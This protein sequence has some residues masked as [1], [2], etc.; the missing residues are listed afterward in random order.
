M[1]NSSSGEMLAEAI[2]YAKAGLRI[3]P[4]RPLSKEPAIKAWQD[5][6]TAETVMIERW[7]G[8]RPSANIGLACGPQPNGLN[9]LA[10]DLDP[11]HGGLETWGQLI[12]EHPTTFTGATIHTTPNGGNHV[13]TN[14]PSEYRNTRAKLGPGIDTRGAGGYV[15]LPPSRV[16]DLNG[17]V[18]TYERR[19]MTALTDAT[20]IE[21]WPW[22]LAR[23]SQNV[24][25]N[26]NGHVVSP[27]VI[28]GTSP[29]DLLRAGWD[30]HG[31]L[32]ADGWRHVKDQGGDRYYAR[33]GKTDRGHSAVVH[34]SGA[35]V[36]FTT[37]APAALERIGRPTSD[38]T[39]FSVSPAHYVTAMRFGGDASAAARWAKERFG[40]ASA[41]G[42]HLSGPA[43]ADVNGVISP[44]AAP[45]TLIVDPGFW[46]ESALLAHVHTAAW[47]V[48][49]APMA[50]L[51]AVLARYATL[52]PPG[53][54][55]P[56]Y[57]SATATF[58][59]MTVIAGRSGAGKT[60]MLRRAAELIPI[61]DTQLLMERG[62]G[63]GEGLIEAFYGNVKVQG[64]D[65]K[66][67]SE[68][69]Q[70]RNGVNFSIDE[71]A[72]F[73]ELG[74][75]A[76]TTHVSRLCSAWSGAPLS[77][78]NA[79]QETIRHLEHGQYRLTACMG[80]QT[81]LG[82]TLMNTDV[83]TQGFTGRLL[84]GWGEDPGKPEPG[85]R[86]DDPGELAVAVPPVIQI[87][88]R[89]ERVDVAY[90]E[91][92]F[93]EVQ[94]NDHRREGTD[95]P[96]VEHHHD[97]LRLKIA[98]ILAL[99]EN[100]RSVSER[101]W[102]L[103]TVLGDHSRAVRSHLQIVHS[104]E[105]RVARHSAAAV[106]AD[107]ELVIESVKER[108][109]IASMAANIRTKTPQEGI[110]RNKLSKVVSATKTRHRFEAALELA[111]S[112]GWVTS[113]GERVSRA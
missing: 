18:Q 20:L 108:Q 112:N 57:L 97:L 89:H 82:H 98:G 28:N 29:F 33:P 105:S 4:L 61:S 60:S 24:I 76:G 102:G 113:D 6:A 40:N 27:A 12:A 100:E 17:E 109:G 48:G 64:D 36:V 39:G 59:L 83:T 111:I 68:R 51:M 71:G 72:I 26:G 96:L 79:Q 22:A 32:L 10:I 91:A 69:R 31:E 53:Y 3:F 16:P 73:A 2:A 8:E 52:I 38:G 94:W 103:A 90:A 77:V 70:V 58:D 93:S 56:P 106:R 30:W 25:S 104:A 47:S 74:G 34:P 63:S 66:T 55:I 13:F 107:T 85:N 88:G 110:G 46:T 65:G 99:M 45:D 9:V 87:A 21:T 44:S 23:L 62:L 75:R 78:Q 35:F 95:V 84:F 15:V 49:R 43:P 11:Q 86:P 54:V 50:L 14:A 7:F 19:T 1:L 101:H 41:G 67:H 5:L 80:I 81:S 42:F 92:I 37:E